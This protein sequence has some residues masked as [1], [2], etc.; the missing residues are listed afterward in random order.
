MR[1]T[2]YTRIKVSNQSFKFLWHENRKIRTKEPK[3][4][5]RKDHN[6]KFKAGDN[7]TKKENSKEKSTKLEV[8][9]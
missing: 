8:N 2:T 4:N 6:N 9:S 3:A 7:E 5:R 1:L